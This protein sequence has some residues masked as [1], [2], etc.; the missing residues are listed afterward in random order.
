[1][2]FTVKPIITGQTVEKPVVTKQTIVEPKIPVIT[3]HAAVATE[4]TE[5]FGVPTLKFT[6]DEVR[7]DTA[8]KIW[9]FTEKSLSYT[10]VC[11]VQTDV[12]RE[13]FTLAGF[14]CSH[15]YQ[16]AL[17]F[18][19]KTR[20]HNSKHNS[21]PSP[22]N[23]IVSWKPRVHRLKWLWST[24]VTAPRT[25]IRVK[26]RLFRNAVSCLRIRLV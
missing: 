10:R 11:R 15:V 7:T 6:N 19:V 5:L 12:Y 14:C 21:F 1:M 4:N 3:V 25:H 17:G 8:F 16:N 22:R 26:V 20:T 2:I 24:E 13:Q 23:V 9:I 18:L